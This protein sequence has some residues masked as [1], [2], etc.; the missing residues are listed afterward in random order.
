MIDNIDHYSYSELEEEIKRI[1]F[2]ICLDS[3]G[4]IS[5][6]INSGSFWISL[7]TDNNITNTKFFKLFLN[8][9]NLKDP[10]FICQVALDTIS[11]EVFLSFNPNRY[12]KFTSLTRLEKTIT[13]TV[14]NYLE[15]VILE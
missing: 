12:I 10:G 3:R 9:K 13:L 11:S 7:S 5:D 4:Y 15:K 14:I 6:K 2:S 1:L 8:K